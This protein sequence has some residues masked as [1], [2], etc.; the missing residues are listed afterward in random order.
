MNRVAGIPTPLPD[1][2][3]HQRVAFRTH[4]VQDESV[5]QPW[6]ARRSSGIAVWPHDTLQLLSWLQNDAEQSP[7]VE[8]ACIGADRFGLAD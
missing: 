8:A 6:G 7:L 2:G 3:L 5:E 4:P 1:G